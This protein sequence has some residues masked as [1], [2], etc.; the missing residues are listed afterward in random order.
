[1]ENYPKVFIVI[2]NYNRKDRLKKCLDSVFQIKYPNFEVIIVDNNSSDGSFE[3]ARKGYSRA[4]LIKNEANLGYSSG[5]N[6]G[7][8]YA[9]ERKADYILLLNNDTE[10]R[11]NFLSSLISVAEGDA[12]IGILSPLIFDGYTGKVWF[13]GGKIDWLRMKAVNLSEIKHKNNFSSDFISG[14]AML[15]KK[16]VFQKTGLLDED[17]FLYW[18]DVDFSLR[19]KRSGFKIGV[20]VSSWIDHFERRKNAGNSKVYWL[21]LSGLLFFRKN[22]RGFLRFWIFFYTYLRRMKNLIDVE[23]LKT[24]T[25]KSVQKAYGD[26]ERKKN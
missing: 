18:E 2:L 14:C 21:V 20:A 5:N 22:S 25:S 13:S 9:L 24:E 15:V 8:R 1:M 12:M 10:V 26:F 17:F 7:I 3:M 4:I 6:V 19:A 16:E 11:A 23:F